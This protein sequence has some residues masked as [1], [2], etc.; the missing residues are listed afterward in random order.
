M[1]KVQT[2][3]RGSAEEL[4]ATGL[5]SDWPCQRLESAGQ[6]RVWLPLGRM[7]RE[8]CVCDRKGRPRPSRLAPENDAF[9]TATK[10]RPWELCPTS[11]LVS[12]HQLLTGTQA[13]TS[14]VTQGTIPPEEYDGQAQKGQGTPL[15]ACRGLG[16][17][18]FAGCE[19]PGDDSSIC[20]PENQHAP[21]PGHTGVRT[22]GHMARVAK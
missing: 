19:Q 13:D 7:P 6:A 17:A 4:Q 11:I 14:L 21:P 12:T 2:P 1:V 16:M 22:S 10:D 9:P 18:V 20:S 15:R 3:V 5:R 8:S